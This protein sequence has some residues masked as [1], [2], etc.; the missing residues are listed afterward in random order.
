MQ[1]VYEEKRLYLNL[2]HPIA[3]GL[4]ALFTA[5]SGSILGLIFSLMFPEKPGEHNKRD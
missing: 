2:S 5:V 3:L 1:A 4:V